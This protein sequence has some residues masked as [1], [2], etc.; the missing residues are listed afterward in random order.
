MNKGLIIQQRVASNG[1]WSSQEQI[2]ETVYSWKLIDVFI[3][4]PMGIVYTEQL[5]CVSTLKI[6]YLKCTCSL[7]KQCLFSANNIDITGIVIARQIVEL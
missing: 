6:L 2:D 7:N 4:V 1:D 3:F 5:S